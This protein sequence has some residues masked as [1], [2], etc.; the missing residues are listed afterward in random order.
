MRSSKVLTAA[1]ILVLVAVVSA[2]KAS[3]GDRRNHGN[4]EH[5]AYVMVTGSNIPQ[6]VKIKNIGTTT[7]SP[8]RNYDRDE[9]DKTGRFSTEEVLRTDPS[10][11]VRGFGQAGPGN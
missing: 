3:A 11:T 4:D 6:K 9:I 7:T 10:L 8:M 2:T 5:Y 1:T